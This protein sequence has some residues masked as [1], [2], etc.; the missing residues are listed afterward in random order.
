M[1]SPFISIHQYSQFKHADLPGYTVT[2]KKL[3][4]LDS[5]ER[6]PVSLTE[7]VLGRQVLAV[8]RRSYSSG[9]L[10]DSTVT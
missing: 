3:E 9:V 10:F 8:S 5:F 4:Y 7:S 1:Y 6:Q 2:C